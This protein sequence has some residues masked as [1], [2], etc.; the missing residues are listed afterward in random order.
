MPLKFIQFP[1]TLMR[2][3]KCEHNDRLI[4]EGQTLN[5]YLIYCIS[6]TP[7]AILGHWIYMFKRKYIS[8][9]AQ[10]GDRTYFMTTPYNIQHTMHS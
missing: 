1:L 3:V 4:K 7:N 9:S 5:L 10:L 8:T 2:H 6:N